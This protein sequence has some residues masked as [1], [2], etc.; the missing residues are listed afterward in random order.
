MLPSLKDWTK[1][2]DDW[3]ATYT[4]ERELLKG[5]SGQEKH[6]SVLRIHQELAQAE[7]ARIRKIEQHEAETFGPS[8]YPC[9]LPD[10]DSHS[11][12]LDTDDTDDGLFMP[13]PPHDFYFHGTS[14]GI[15]VVCGQ[16]GALGKITRLSKLLDIDGMYLEAGER[17]YL[18][19]ISRRDDM[20]DRYLF[21]NAIFVTSA[22]AERQIRP[23]RAVMAY[24]A[25]RSFW[26]KKRRKQRFPP[27]SYFLTRAI[28]KIPKVNVV[29]IEE[30]HIQETYSVQPVGL[31]NTLVLFGQ[32]IPVPCLKVT[33]SWFLS[34]PDPESLFGLEDMPVHVDKIV[35]DVVG[36]T[37]LIGNHARSGFCPLSELFV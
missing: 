13:D 6:D 4:K 7:L 28:L 35:T 25:F 34:Q 8:P 3:L 26:Q 20:K 27:L 37:V 16:E 1:L 9:I 22:Y 19:D 31:S 12:T 36:K 24:Y 15:A 5:L 17:T 11:V 29:S 10:S 18:F 33:E 14:L 23:G 32:Q 21:G 30:G 2:R